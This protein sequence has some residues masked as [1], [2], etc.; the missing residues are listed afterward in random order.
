MPRSSNPSGWRP[1]VGATYANGKGRTRRVVAMGSEYLLYPG[2]GD[3]DCL[4]YEADGEQGNMTV[5]SFR[6]WAKGG[7]VDA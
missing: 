2:Q 5:N 6:K 4:R 3:H 1:E 7:R